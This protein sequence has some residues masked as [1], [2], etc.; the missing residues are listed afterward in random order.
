VSCE[1][2]LWDENEIVVHPEE[3][4][5]AKSGSFI[6]AARSAN[7]IVREDIIPQNEAFEIP[8]QLR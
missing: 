6:E 3:R 2:V 7:D 4:D 5:P 1:S 8:Q